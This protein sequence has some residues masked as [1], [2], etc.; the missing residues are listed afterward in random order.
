[1]TEVD[2]YVL[3]SDDPAARAHCACRLAD[4]AFRH[5]VTVYLHTGGEPQARELDTLLW[6]FR[7]E[8]FLPHALLGEPHSDRV[9]I[10]WGADPGEHH[11][12]MINMD[13]QVPA[14]VG[15][16]KRVF[17][18]VAA[19]NPAIREP[20]RASWKWYA[21]RGYQLKKNNL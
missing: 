12:L 11:D 14:F 20:L 9:G 17:E 7:P 18:I 5:G 4:K 13:L 10:G 21:D 1:M 19:N 8:S 6:A 15:R 2:F 3:Q 16:F